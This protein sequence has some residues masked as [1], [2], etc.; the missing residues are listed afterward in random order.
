M[1]NGYQPMVLIR[2]IRLWGGKRRFEKTI[3]LENGLGVMQA[4]VSLGSYATVDEEVVGKSR[5]KHVEYV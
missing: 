4:A 2:W 3:V 5:P 1:P